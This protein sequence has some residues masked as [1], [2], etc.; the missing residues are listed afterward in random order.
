MKYGLDTKKLAGIGIFSAL[1]FVLYLVKFP[2]PVLFPFWLEFKFADIP[3]LIGSF[4]YG[5]VSGI[6]IIVLRTLLKLLVQGTSTV[7]VGELG[8]LLLGIAFVV[9][10]SLVY[11][12]LK[13]KYKALIGILTG[14]V[15][16]VV[17]AIIINRFLL[18]PYYVELFFGGDFSAI[19]NATKSVFKNV[20]EQ[21]FYKYYLWTAVLPFNLIIAVIDGALTL[22]VNKF[23][24]KYLKS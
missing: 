1:S 12:F 19:V 18:V 3:A 10:S 2:L 7:F 17:T 22:V 11:A 4:A 8:D 9:P 16:Y 5:P 23:I 24:G 14:S 15:C 21:N 6:A 20:N 13:N